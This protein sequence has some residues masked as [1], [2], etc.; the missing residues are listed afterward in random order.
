MKELYWVIEFD[1][2]EDENNTLYFKNFDIAFQNYKKIKEEHQKDK[3]FTVCENP[4]N[5]FYQ[6]S[7]YDS[8]YNEYNTFVTL[9]QRTMPKVWDEIIF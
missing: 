5:S 6:C 4:N 9:G 1:N 2:Y 3:E 7:W 8:R